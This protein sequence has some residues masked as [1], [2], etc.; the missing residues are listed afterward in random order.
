MIL[1][2]NKKRSK[3]EKSQ[4]KRRWV[5]RRLFL[6]IT[7]STRKNPQEWRGTSFSIGVNRAQDN[8]GIKWRMY[9]TIE[10]NQKGAIKLS[11]SLPL[12]INSID[13]STK[14]QLTLK[15]EL[16][17]KIKLYHGP[18]KPASKSQGLRTFSQQVI[19]CNWTPGQSRA[20][21]L[22]LGS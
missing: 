3:L 12:R 10:A 16:K 1:L 9:F 4:S 15:K 14:D 13:R 2:V 21:C 5:R 11:K 7:H 8:K 20:K 17:G 19:L 6:M 18:S 22:S